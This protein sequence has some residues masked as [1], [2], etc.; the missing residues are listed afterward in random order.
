MTYSSE[1]LADSPA[2]F[3]RF[4][5]SSGN[6]LDS[7]GNGRDFSV[8]GSAGTRAAT[9]L[10]VGDANAGFS[11]DSTSF[12]LHAYRNY[13]SAMNPSSFT[14]AVIVK[15]V[16]RASAREWYT[17][18]RRSSGG[19][20]LALQQISGDTYK[21]YAAWD[22]AAGSKTVQ[23][24]SSFLITASPKL[25]IQLTYD[26]TNVKLWV[27]GILEG[28][29]ASGAVSWGTGGLAVGTWDSS[30][31][32]YPFQ[33]TIDEF[34][35]T[36]TALSDARLKARYGAAQPVQIIEQV[37][38][39][40][41]ST[42]TPTATLT[43]IPQPGDMLVVAMDTWST[44]AR[45]ISSISGGGATWSS[46]VD[47]TRTGIW[48]GVS[49][50]TLAAVGAV[51]TTL[52]GSAN[53]QATVY[54]VRGLTSTA[55][56]GFAS[57]AGTSDGLPVM[58][59]AGQAVFACY[60]AGSTTTGN[61]P[62]TPSPSDWVQDGTL[63]DHHGFTHRIPTETKVMHK[64][65]TDSGQT[66]RQLTIMVIGARV[67]DTP[68]GGSGTRV[69]EHIQSGVISA[70]SGVPC[71]AKDGFILTTT[72]LAGDVVEVTISNSGSIART[73]S[74]VSGMGASWTVAFTG[75][76][77]RDWILVGTGA[78]YVDG[79]ISVTF[80]GGATVVMDA[81]L[82]RE[83]ANT[84][85][86]TSV[87]SGSGTTGPAIDAAIG[88]VVT[89]VVA[90]SSGTE[91]FA[92]TKVPSSGWNVN[93]QP[94]A[95]MRSAYRV[96][97]ET[98]LTAHRLD[99]TV[100]FSGRIQTIAT[101]G[102]PPGPM[103][104]LAATMPALGAQLNAETPPQIQTAGQMPALA[105]QLGVEVPPDA[106]L[107]AAMPALGALF[108]VQAVPDQVT[109]VLNAT[110]PALTGG[111]IAES[112]DAQL[113]ATM[114]TLGAAIIVDLH[115]TT[116]AGQMPA[117]AG[118]FVVDVPPPPTY[119]SD[120]QGFGGLLGYWPLDELT[121][122]THDNDG[123]A[124]STSTR[125]GGPIA[126]A[127]IGKPALMS[128]EPYSIQNLYT[129]PIYRFTAD[130]SAFRVPTFTAHIWL[131]PED[132]AHTTISQ[133]YGKATWGGSGGSGDNA[134]KHW[135][136]RLDNGRIVGSVWYGSTEY[137]IQTPVSYVTVGAIYHVA[138]VVEQGVSA[139][140]GHMYLYI[141]G[142]LYGDIST[143]TSSNYAST[144][145]VGVFQ[146]YDN[147]MD[148][149]G[150][151]AAPAFHNVALSGAQIADL[152]SDW[153][154]PPPDPEVSLAGQMPQPTAAFQT[155]VLSPADA[156]LAGQM[157]KPTGSFAVTVEGGVEEVGVL[158]LT[159]QMP[160]FGAHFDLTGEII[161]DVELDATMPTLGA[162]VG[163][164][165]VYEVGQSMP[166]LRWQF[167][168]MNTYEIYIV[169][170]NPKQASSHRLA[171]AFDS[172]RHGGQRMRMTKTASQP[173]DW[174]FGGVVRSH[175]HHDALIDWQKRPGKVRVTDHLGRTFEVMM[176]SLEMTDR[177]PAGDNTWRF[178]YT[179][180]CLLLR[181]IG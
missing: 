143:P 17:I 97:S 125:L 108:D 173:T 8:G 179:F 167:Q 21:V 55:A 141:N 161:S 62:T 144:H 72:P 39:T 49:P 157:P 33:G 23:S 35:L 46:V 122:N 96:P 25:N 42:A 28:T 136:I 74:A 131:T 26:G 87:A 83:L 69:V 89:A 137:K 78:T 149:F 71:G 129:N 117:L 121:G 139:G 105:A 120:L 27:N 103:A 6:F 98:S 67:A 142:A 73:I 4:G 150:R 50:S 56:I 60:A 15:P 109:A 101:I 133:V 30:N 61:F 79:G 100:S 64:V 81:Y 124:S 180:N 53:T 19:F 181:R 5:E 24:A 11:V 168:D 128:G 127:Q 20:W 34:S 13:E 158:D 130:E 45:T 80:S 3:L 86:T 154:L 2:Y 163:V 48:K 112:L 18:A 148:F 38:S 123:S 156:T 92:A 174:T 32:T 113:A 47:G 75:A 132:L 153:T 52:T 166:F 147:L 59:G 107:A 41:A 77:G 1:V 22:T 51:V 111:L 102:L 165:P 171:K 114:P 160:S 177:R 68:D 138:L 110:M 152:Y 118:A 91:D 7:S 140:P 176:R 54:L 10:L 12:S 135:A 162:I 88:Q 36:P 82:I 134:N 16:T 44:T 90:V 146:T 151:V 164:L 84:T 106:A 115:D 85:V 9:G 70:T 172:A 126:L 116:L 178:E 119:K 65:S 66:G 155:A 58:A 37:Q 93:A 14:M 57:P 94:S 29:T 63:L 31:Y 40:A 169:E 76:S 104:T 99:P 170:L 43:S 145:Q 175:T 95:L 159:A